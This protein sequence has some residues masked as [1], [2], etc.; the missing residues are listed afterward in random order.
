[1][2]LKKNSED[3]SSV[4]E[5]PMKRGLTPQQIQQ[6]H[7]DGCLIVRDLLPREALQPLIDE[8]VQKVDDLAN[9]AVRQGLLDAANTFEDTPFETRLALVSDAC[10]E[11][12]WLWRQVHGKQ[13]KTAGMF[14]LRTWAALLDVVESLIGPEILAHPQTVLRVKLPDQEE[15]VVP[16][17][18][19][20]AYLKPEEAG[21][22][23]VVNFWVPLV[24]ATAANGCMQVMCG[25]HRFGLLP[26]NYRISI[27][28]GVAD[29]N[30]PPCETVT[31]EVN[32]GDVL[33]TM[34][35]LLHRSIPNTSNTVR[36][37]VDTRYS[38]IGLPT[39]RE[40]VPGFV[41]RSRKNPECVARSHH[42][43][44]R[45]LTE[46]GLDPFR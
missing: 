8:L 1:M 38:R 10:S 40:N 20:L 32:A 6:F 33:M 25:S 34:E 21:D 17:H 13:Q 18:Q 27:Y 9:E 16:W 39:G 28:K 7:D 36:W 19:D 35:R 2:P 23:L 30:L 15:T 14:T 24:R 46:A 37:S 44:I 29:A 3:R 43:W 11:R 41:A 26:H 22:T 42:D 45:L 12:N 5:S 4:E 31:C